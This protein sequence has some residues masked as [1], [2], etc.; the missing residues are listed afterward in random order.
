M[1]TLLADG[2]DDTGGRLAGRTPVFARGTPT[3]PPPPCASERMA[4]V[5]PTPL[6]FALGAWVAATPGAD[7]V[8][9]ALISDPGR[10]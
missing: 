4:A 9:C 6:T 2:A 3:P 10:G 8:D 5:S 7:R 1:M